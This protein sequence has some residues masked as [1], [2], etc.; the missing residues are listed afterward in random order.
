MADPSRR[1]FADLSLLS[2][3]VISLFFEPSTWPDRWDGPLLFSLLVTGVLA[4]TY[5]LWVQTRMQRYTT[6]TR[7]AIVFTM[8]PVSAAIFGV[9]L[10]GETLSLGQMIGGGLIVAAMLLAELR[11]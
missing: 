11:H 7:T 4:T 9:W 3:A 5:A 8:E 6:P 1:L 10:G 2:V